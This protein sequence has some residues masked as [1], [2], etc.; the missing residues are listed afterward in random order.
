MCSLFWFAGMGPTLLSVGTS[1]VRLL[2][3]IACCY[4]EFLLCLSLAG[5]YVLACM[6]LV[7]LPYPLLTH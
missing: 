3:T 2:L 7:M 1:E 6:L 4:V 5:F